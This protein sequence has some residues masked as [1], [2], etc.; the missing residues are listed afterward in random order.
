[1]SPDIKPVA[2]STW[3]GT[4][5]YFSAFQ[6]TARKHGIEVMNADPAFWPGTSWQDKEWFRKT[7]SQ[8][9]FIME[10]PEFTHF[11]FTDA[12]DI[13]FATGWDEIMEKFFK[14]DSPIVFG[15]ECWPW[16]KVQ[17]ETLYPQVP[18]R[19]KFLNAGFWIGER[20]EALKFMAEATVRASKREQCDQGIFVDLFL[21]K[22]H[23]IKLD[24][25]CSLCF[26]CNLN[27][28]DF[29]EK[30]DG[31]P[32]CKDTGENPCVFHGNG[33]SPLFKVIEML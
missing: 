9:R 33:N 6:S 28:L 16:P 3:Y 17:Q 27:S 18:Y 4:D 19:C 1:M 26:C 31:R 14:L 23:P 11:M 20:R 15:A 2:V 22:E 29:L 24:N 13:V 5:K 32:T 12:Y 7:Q 8:H 10:H 21:S 25:A 30:K